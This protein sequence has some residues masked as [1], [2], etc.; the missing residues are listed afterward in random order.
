MFSPN[1]YNPA[2]GGMF[3]QQN[4]AGM[5][6]APPMQSYMQQQQAFEQAQ[7]I[8]Q[9]PQQAQKVMCYNVSTKD[10]MQSLETFPNIYYIGINKKAKEIY[11]R[12]W[13]NDGLIDFDTYVLS[14]G[15]QET[16]S[17]KTILDKLE[18]IENQL[19]M[20]P[21]PTQ[22]NV[23]NTQQE[24]GNGYVNTKFNTTNYD[25]TAPKPPVNGTVQSNDG[26]KKYSTTASNS[27]EHR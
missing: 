19:H 4:L 14:K 23:G 8:Q 7:A 21:T 2:M 20:T 1:F 5:P 26:R 17:M 24:G 3:Q 10:E 27:S 18:S 16:S 13:R 11:V 6:P 12:S 15:E 25:G 9:I 22:Q